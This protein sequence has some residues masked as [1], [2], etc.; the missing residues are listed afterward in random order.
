MQAPKKHGKN[1]F[2]AYD[3]G[4]GSFVARH[5]DQVL[6]RYIVEFEAAPGE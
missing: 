3:N 1:D 4:A 6:P 5:P 2:D